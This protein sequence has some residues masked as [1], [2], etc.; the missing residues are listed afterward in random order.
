VQRYIL[1]RDKQDNKALRKA[2]N[3]AAAAKRQKEA[4]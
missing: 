4:A 2:Q 3:D 1:E